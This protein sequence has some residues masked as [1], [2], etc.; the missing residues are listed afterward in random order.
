M[1]KGV[2]DNASTFLRFH[3]PA[4]QGEAR[5]A[6]TAPWAPVSNYSWVLAL[7]GMA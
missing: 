6:V 1:V 2:E 4:F 5:R 7:S 3:I